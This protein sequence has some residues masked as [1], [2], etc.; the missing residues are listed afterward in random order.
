MITLCVDP[1]LRNLSFCI[2]NS[3]YE[4]LLW[5]TFNILDSDDYH[6][7][8]LFKN[9]KVCNRKCIM[10]YKKEDTIVIVVDDGSL[11]N[12]HIIWM[13]EIFSMITIIEK[14]WKTAFFIE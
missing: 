10:K 4:I 11:I 7:E 6:C 8:S 2:M 9:G 13:K 1:G 14:K 3:E 5:D 12:D